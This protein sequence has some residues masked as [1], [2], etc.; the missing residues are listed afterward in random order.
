M[1]YTRLNQCKRESVSGGGGSH[2]FTPS[3]WESQAF[4]SSTREVETGRDRTEQ[5]EGNKAG[6]DRSSRH[7]RL[8]FCRDSIQSEDS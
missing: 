6:G 8:R 4:N 7:S 2:I 3:T 5:S 1:G